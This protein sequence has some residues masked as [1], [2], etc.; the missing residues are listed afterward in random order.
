MNN[1]EEQLES[2]LIEFYKEKELLE[3]HLGTSD[4]KQIVEII[5][6][7]QMQLS[8]LYKEQEEHH[9]IDAKLVQIIGNKKVYIKQVEKQ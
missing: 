1:T 8:E 4:P 3:Q 9:I 2:Q 5:Q 7:M 6:S